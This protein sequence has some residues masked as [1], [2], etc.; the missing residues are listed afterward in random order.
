MLDILDDLIVFSNTAEENAQRLE[1]ILRTLDD[2]NLQFQ[3]GKCV[4][5]QTEVRYLGYVLSERGVS[6]SVTK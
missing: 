5:A 1:D 3:P 2:A 4:I 6:A